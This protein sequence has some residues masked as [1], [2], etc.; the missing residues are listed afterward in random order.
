MR[1]TWA[2]FAV[3]GCTSSRPPLACPVRSDAAVRVEKSVVEYDV[4]GA[5]FEAFVERARVKPASR[6][7]DDETLA[8]G[9][10]EARF[11][12]A[13]DPEPFSGGCRLT[14][15]V[16][17]LSAR[18]LLPRWTAAPHDPTRYKAWR[19]A[20]AAHEEGHYAI[21]LHAARTIHAALSTLPPQPDCGLLIGRASIVV[22]QILNDTRARNRE[23]DR[24]H[25]ELP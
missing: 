9:V 16:V 17:G 23:W 11:C 8:V 1:A 18:I 3:L 6:I 22:E 24:T 19:D 21:D 20:V 4:D 7:V 15:P 13:Y 5:T 10:T 14:T 2:L 25:S 12:V